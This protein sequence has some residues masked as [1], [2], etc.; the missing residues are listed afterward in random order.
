MF[1]DLNMKAQEGLLGFLKNENKHLSDVQGR[2]ER[3]CKAA[4]M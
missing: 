1:H 4:R 3:F 2:S